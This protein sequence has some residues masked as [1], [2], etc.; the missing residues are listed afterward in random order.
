M[1]NEQDLEFILNF[2]LWFLITF[3]VLKLFLVKLLVE[4]E[5][6]AVSTAD[7]WCAELEP[8]VLRCSQTKL[9][10]IDWKCSGI[11]GLSLL[12]A[13]VMAYPSKTTEKIRKLMLGGTIL[14]VVN[15]IRLILVPRF[16][17][18]HEAFWMLEAFLI[19]LVFRYT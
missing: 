6:R 17:W 11:V 13:L 7:P 4:L 3:L 10:V 1:L 5:T 16:P 18:V 9:L 15:L 2:V 8:G 19:L 14:L 12:A